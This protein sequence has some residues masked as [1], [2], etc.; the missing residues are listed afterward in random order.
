MRGP[1]S[2]KHGLE[3]LGG[4]PA[5]ALLLRRLCPPLPLSLQSLLLL[6]PQPLPALLQPALLHALG[7][8]HLLPSAQRQMLL[9]LLQLP[10][11]VQP[12]PQPHILPLPRSPLLHPPPPLARLPVRWLHMLLALLLVLLLAPVGLLA[13]APQLLLQEGAQVRQAAQALALV[14]G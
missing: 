8:P 9:L 12:P 13:S 6:L 10:Q 5:L 3:C 1:T 2:C 11:A 14:L 4:A 7:C